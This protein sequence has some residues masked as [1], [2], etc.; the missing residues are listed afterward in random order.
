MCGLGL[1]LRLY[2]MIIF[3]TRGFLLGQ[4][5]RLVLVTMAGGLVRGSR[6]INKTENKPLK[7]QH[8]HVLRSPRVLNTWLC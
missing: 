3:D 4:T 5:N 8:Y 7:P 6:G 1:A 2:L